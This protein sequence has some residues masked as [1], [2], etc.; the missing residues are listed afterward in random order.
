M[1]KDET[2]GGYLR[3]HER[4]PAF[5]AADGHAYTV[6]LIVEPLD[7]EDGD[8]W[9]GYLFFLKWRGNEPVGHVETEF[10]SSA[11]SADEARDPI[12]R[13]TLHD[14]KALLDELVAT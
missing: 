3:E 13:L 6:E 5:Q 14:V 2:L 9:G 1:M 8:E 12:E 7:P 10:L 11:S 4:P